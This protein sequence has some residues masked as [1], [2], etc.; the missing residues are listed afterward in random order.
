MP[1][2]NIDDYVNGGMR[3]EVSW[4][5]SGYVQVATTN[6]HSP[7][8][9]P[10]EDQPLPSGH[11]ATAVTTNP[12]PGGTELPFDGWYAT[13]DRDGINRAIRALR[14]ARDAAYGRDE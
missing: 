10:P 9:M 12:P 1:K 5:S 4:S 7:F 2:E 14:R 3:L 6:A 13:L 8:T 11:P